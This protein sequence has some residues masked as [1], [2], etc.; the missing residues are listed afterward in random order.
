MRDHSLARVVDRRRSTARRRRRFAAGRSEMR[1]AI[2]LATRWARPLAFAIPLAIA[3][4]AAVPPSGAAAQSARE[5]LDR[6]LSAL[7]AGRFREAVTDLDA[8]YR[9]EQTPLTLYNLGLAY[10]GLGYPGKAV[11]AFEAYV[12][13]ADAKK[14]DKTIAAVQK[15]IARIKEGYAR[16]ALT[17]DPADATIQIDGKPAGLENG[18]LWVEPGQHRI[19]IT[20]DG[21]EDYE[22]ILEMQAGRFELDVHL[23]KPSGPP[24]V[25]AAALLDEGDGLQAA[26][27]IGNAAAKFS[28]AQRI[29]PTPRG[30]G[31]LGLAQEAMGE[32]AQAEGNVQKALRSPRDK[33]VRKNRRKLKESARRLDRVLATFVITGPDHPG[34]EVFIDD[35]PIG[36]LPLEGTGEVRAEGG[37]RIITAKLDGYDDYYNETEIPARGRRAIVITMNKSAPPPVVAAVVPAAAAAGAG[38]GVGAAAGA[39]SEKPAEPAPPPDEP[40]PAAA[41]EPAGEELATEDPTQADIE[42]MSQPFEEG[43]PPDEYP[44]V[45]GLEMAVGV[46]YQ[47]WLDDPEGDA[48]GALAGRLFSIGYRPFW[49]ISFGLRILDMHYDLGTDAR[50]ALGGGPAIYVRGHVQRDYK[51]LTFDAWAGVA[52]QPVVFS[53]ASYEAKDVSA[54]DLASLDESDATDALQAGLGIGDTVTVQTYNVPLEIGGA[55]YITKGMAVELTA[56]F[57]F[58]IP[59]QKCYWDA[60]DHVCFSDQLDTLKSIYIGAGLSFLP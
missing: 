17:L 43:E 24:D 7:K 18:E 6:G 59:T 12:S 23:R 53:V 21:Y 44:A 36:S 48:G 9:I 50:F 37:V 51:P 4:I 40:L 46:G 15:E 57:S 5:L 42:A 49:P 39:L 3:L 13:F 34:A 14:D 19:Q 31:S 10:N 26:G 47:V 45:A 2:R 29:Y 55:F 38:A 27:D 30:A 22:Q 58:W 60:S 8:S 54:T 56:A 28:A 11:A 32:L 16:F 41:T 1:L 35:R 20:A 52:F 25:R 33:W